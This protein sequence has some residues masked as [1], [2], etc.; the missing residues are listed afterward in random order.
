MIQLGVIGTSWISH[1]FV[2][3]ALETKQYELAGVYSRRAE[4]AKEFA[5][6]HSQTCWTTADFTAFVASD[7]LTTIYIASPNSYH[8]EQ[9]KAAILAGKHVIVEKPAFTNPEQMTTIL[10]LAKQQGVLFFEAARNIHEENY[11]R[12]SQFLA[13]HG[14]VTGASLTY[15]KY[16]SRYDDVLA[17][18]EPNIFSLNFAGGAL[19]DLGVYLIYAA[20]GWFGQPQQSNYFATKIRTGVDGSGWGVLRYEGFDVSIH[21]GKTGH[22]AAAAEIYLADGTLVIDG[23]QA[24]TQAIFYPNK[25]QEPYGLALVPSATNPLSEEAAVFATYL[26]TPDK[27]SQTQAYQEITSLARQ[28]NQTLYQ[29]RTMAAITFPSDQIT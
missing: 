9:A 27:W 4:V 12:V 28:V 14:P 6:E 29:M 22:S 24:I 15:M 18:H 26:A 20:V 10:T 5:N 21:T 1:Q 19:M 11:R 25:K 8:F 3:A 7:R 13:E 17:G 2:A 23:V 16:S